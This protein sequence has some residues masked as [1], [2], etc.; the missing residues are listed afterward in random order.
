MLLYDI[1]HEQICDCKTH[2]V[3]RI[4]KFIHKIQLSQYVYMIQGLA[5]AVRSRT[6]RERLLTLTGDI[7]TFLTCPLGMRPSDQV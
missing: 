5:H 1:I 4:Q 6:E 2:V 7:E 3:G